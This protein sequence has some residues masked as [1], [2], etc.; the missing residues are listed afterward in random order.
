MSSV[1]AQCS[2]GWWTRRA[3]CA[4]LLLAAAPGCGESPGDVRTAAPTPKPAWRS[5]VLLAELVWREPLFAPPMPPHDV[6]AVTPQSPPQQTPALFDLVPLPPLEEPPAPMVE[7]EAIANAVTELERSAPQATPEG[8]TL[9]QLPTPDEFAAIAAAELDNVSTAEPSAVPPAESTPPEMPAGAAASEPLTPESI[10]QEVEPTPPS[11][12]IAQESVPT[13]LP[14]AEPLPLPLPDEDTDADA[15]V[16]LLADAAP[17]LTGLPT[18]A[19]VNE[20]AQAKIRR[21]Y[22]LAQRGANFAARSEFIE[23][24]RMIAEAK[25]QIHGAQRR[26]IALADGLRALD[27][28]ADFAPRGPEVDAGLSIAVIVS[29]H[30]TPVGKTA[31]AQG[32]MPQKLADL[33][34]RYA[35]LQL[36][37]AVA[38][39]PAGSMALH[40]L[41]KL[42]SQLGRAEPVKHPQAD[43]RAFALQ[44]A[45]L[46]ARNDNHLA[47][48]ELGVLLAQAGHLAEAEQLLG[49]VVVREPHPVVFRNLARVQRKLGR[50]QLAAA[51]EREAEFVASRAASYDGVTWV[52]PD[53]LAQTGDALAPPMPASPQA[54]P[55]QPQPSSRGA[56]PTRNAGLPSRNYRR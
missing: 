41:G 14:P 38:G 29:S 37:A 36:G 2:S 6:P 48:H 52:T 27:E 26:T 55:P 44:Q 45:A 23:V 8:L 51:S 19:T 12:T 18:G 43:R 40:A 22:E 50:E 31:A 25:D 47:A 32:L 42:Y 1:G 13:E 17:N 53:A 54:L 35:Q 11:V 3:A 10:E 4:A 21:G 46:L 34:F 20:R 24:L 16:D 30:H 28:A 9:E 56:A 5:P 15:E 7:A 39:E 33:Y 49:L